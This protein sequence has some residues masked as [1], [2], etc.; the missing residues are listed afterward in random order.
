MKLAISSDEKVPLTDHVVDWLEQHGHEIVLCGSLKG[1]SELWPRASQE[2]AELVAAGECE[3]GVLFCYTGTG[4]SIAANKV[5]GIRA[6]LCVDAQTAKGA[7]RWNHANVLTMG[8][9][10]TTETVADEILEAWFAAPLGVGEDEEA[11]DQVA[12]IERK[13]SKQS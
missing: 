12:E 4:A 7:R 2:L 3:Q 10:N 13:Y 8:Y 6:A 5:P 1:R 9:R 11:V